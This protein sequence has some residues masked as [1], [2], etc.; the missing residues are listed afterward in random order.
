MELGSQ[1]LNSFFSGIHFVQVTSYDH[2]HL[3][4]SPINGDITVDKSIKDVGLVVKVRMLLDVTVVV[5]KGGSAICN[6]LV[7]VTVGVVTLTGG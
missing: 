2:L 6:V 7:V 5:S 1:C 3:V 4:K